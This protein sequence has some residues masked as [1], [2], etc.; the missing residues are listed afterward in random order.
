[1]ADEAG[2]VVGRPRDYKVVAQWS[3]TIVAIALVVTHLSNPQLNIDNTVL[4]LFVIAIIPWLGSVFKT[5]ELPGFA[6]FEY[7]E[8][9]VDTLNSEVAS[10]KE[11][12]SGAIE[13]S[14]K[15]SEA[16]SEAVRLSLAAT[17][18][19]QADPKK[20]LLELADEYVKT[21][22]R[23]PR[24]AQ[25]TGEVSRIFGKMTAVACD[26]KDLEVR[27]LLESEDEGKRLAAI[28]FLY[29]NPDPQAIDELILSVTEQEDKAF[30]QYWGLRTVQKLLGVGG[31]I[32]VMNLGKLREF[33][34]RL[35]RGTDRYFEVNRILAGYQPLNEK[36]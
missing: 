29:A 7:F 10:V 26:L 22:R 33:S 8:K 3:I 36:S 18:T 31:P 20:A 23:L 27:D 11:E 34:G 35:R 30:N 32:S 28:A 5:V 24:G 14:R 13:S 1:M 2:K 16:T 21:R 19:V 12:V 6:K 15:F 17:R 4:A 9:K 25:R